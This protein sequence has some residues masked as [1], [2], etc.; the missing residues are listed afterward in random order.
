MLKE[1]GLKVQMMPCDVS[2]C[3]NSTFNMLNFT[4]DYHIAINMVISN[5]DLN[6]HKY[7][8]ADEEWATAENLCDTL[9]A[10]HFS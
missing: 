3:W 5:R 9:K 10:C 7:K 6:L 4:I 2:T 1:L 8:L